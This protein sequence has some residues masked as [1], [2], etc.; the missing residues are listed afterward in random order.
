MVFFFAD[1]ENSHGNYIVDADGNALLDVFQQFGSL[2]LGKTVCRLHVSPIVVHK[3]IGYNHPAIH[4]T[5]EDPALRTYLAARPALGKVPPMQYPDRI[6][7]TL[8]SVGNC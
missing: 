7:S 1:Y 2:P 6:R 4:K 3:M 5:L 8:M